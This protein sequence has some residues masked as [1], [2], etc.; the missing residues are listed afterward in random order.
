MH[1]AGNL[2]IC[3]NSLA[4]SALRS[5]LVLPLAAASQPNANVLCLVPGSVTGHGAG[6]LGSTMLMVL[7][8]CR[9][10]R[11]GGLQYKSEIAWT[12]VICQTSTNG[13]CATAAA[14][15]VGL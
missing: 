9:R 8:Q 14:R 10:R 1:R 11:A 2:E 13:A 7:Q 3:R 15:P 5:R 4:H 6:G 12:S